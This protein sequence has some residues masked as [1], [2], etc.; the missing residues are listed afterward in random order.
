MNTSYFMKKK[1]FIYFIKFFW[2]K[3]S[4]RKTLDMSLKSF[5]L[6]MKFWV[7]IFYIYL[8]VFKCIQYIKKINQSCRILIFWELRCL[9]N[10]KNSKTMKQSYSYYVYFLK[11]KLEWDLYLYNFVFANF[12]NVFLNMELCLKKWET[13][14]WFCFSWF[15]QKSFF[16][17]SIFKHEHRNC[18]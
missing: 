9:K 1:K 4:K 3:N 12:F 13:C 10:Y 7:V 17:C 6:L 8:A 2:I 16:L 11:I 15:S 5:L 18:F 14:A